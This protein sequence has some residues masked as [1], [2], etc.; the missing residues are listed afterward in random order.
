MVPWNAGSEFSGKR[1]QLVQ[2][3]QDYLLPTY[4]FIGVTERFDESLA[5]MVILFQLE[6]TDVIVM[7]VKQSGGYDDAGDETGQ[8]TRIL[9]PLPPSRTVK[10]HWSHEHAVDN[11]DFLL[12][13]V[14]N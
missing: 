7:S 3:V 11:V 6:P 8:C 2:W 4:D 9:K 13:E 1:N 14:A 12:C 5:V 10:K